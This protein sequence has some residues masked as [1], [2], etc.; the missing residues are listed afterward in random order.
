V[1][2]RGW[3]LLP[4]IFL[5]LGVIFAAKG[6]GR[7]QQLP[8]PPVNPPRLQAPVPATPAPVTPPHPSL[9][10]VVVDPA[11]GGADLGARGATG[12][13]ESDIT[14][15]Y[16]QAMR[17]ALE[18]AGVRVMVTRENNADPSFDDRSA[19]VNGLRGAVFITLHVASTGPFGQVRVYS[20]PLPPDSANSIPVS[21]PA[22][23]GMMPWDRAQ[24]AYAGAS[25]RLAELVQSA[26]ALKFSGSP[27]APL[28]APVRQLRTIGAPAIAI[29]VSSVSTA[30]RSRLAELGHDLADAVAKGIAAFRPVYQE[31]VR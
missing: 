30:D 16:S 22:H 2:K 25:R 18:S 20:Q 24:E 15:I 17:P 19:I 23:N 5:L 10:V 8:P 13:N 27:A 4:N 26:V 1:C 28:S 14:L 11:H 7:Q 9:A 29:E 6:A 3:I 21:F 31:S 12:I